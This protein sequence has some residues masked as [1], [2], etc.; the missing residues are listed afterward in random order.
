MSLDDLRREIDEID[1]KILKSLLTD[2]RTS[3][4]ELSKICNITI[5]AVKNRFNRL[6]KTGIITSEFMYINPFSLG[7]ESISEIGIK[8]ELS[9][10]EP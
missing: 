7:Y 4:T 5:P 2:S 8:T 1:A 9:N 3:F 10:K 6:K